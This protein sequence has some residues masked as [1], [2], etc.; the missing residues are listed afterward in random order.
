MSDTSINPGAV[1]SPVQRAGWFSAH[2]AKFDPIT[3]DPVSIDPGMP[4]TPDPA[5]S[6]GIYAARAN[7]G[8]PAA[9][10][11]GIAVGAGEYPGR[12]SYSVGGPVTLTIEQWNARTG[13]TGGLTPGAVYYVSATAGQITATAP[14]DGFVTP[15][16]FAVDATTLMVQIGA[17][18]ALA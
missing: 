15:V 6:G 14:V 8:A 9:N 5:P 13:L 16:G 4:V 2:P 3:S 18:V 7:N 11:L 1:P 10:V 17:A 12:A